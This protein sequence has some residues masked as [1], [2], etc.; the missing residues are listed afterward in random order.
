MEKRRRP[1]CKELVDAFHFLWRTEQRTLWLVFASAVLLMESGEG[2]SR[3][4][5]MCKMSEKT[6]WWIK[7]VVDG[8]WL[9]DDLK[10]AN[11]PKNLIRS[12]IDHRNFHKG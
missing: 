8:Q 12:W 6:L 10:P 7:R 3:V 11:L 5:Q 9:E 2:D 4:R 1:R